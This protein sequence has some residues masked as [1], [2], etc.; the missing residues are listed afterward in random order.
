MGKTL[1]GQGDQVPALKKVKTI[2]PEMK[3]R[4]NITV[5]GLGAIGVWLPTQLLH[6]V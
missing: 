2:L 3:F 5:I 4:V 6:L 1:I